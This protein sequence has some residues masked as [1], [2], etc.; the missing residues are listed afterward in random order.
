MTFLLR[1]LQARFSKAI[2]FFVFFASAGRL[3]NVGFLPSN[4]SAR[5][6]LNR[7]LGLTLGRCELLWAPL[8]LLQKHAPRPAGASLDHESAFVED[9]A[10]GI[11]RSVGTN[12]I[13]K[14]RALSSRR[15]HQTYRRPEYSPE[16]RVIPHHVASRTPR[17]TS[18]DERPNTLR[19]LTR[20][21]PIRPDWPSLHDRNW[22]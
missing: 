10:S 14:I 13:A 9:A 22:P 2:F 16:R 8:S 20:H 21:S 4:E 15:P 7:F 3:R 6:R 17:E 1:L 5:G 11:S 19:H 18:R 12:A